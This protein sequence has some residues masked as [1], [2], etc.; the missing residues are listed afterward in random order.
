MFRDGFLFFHEQHPRDW[1][2]LSWYVVILFMFLVDCEHI[3]LVGA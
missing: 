2:N 3:T 1:I